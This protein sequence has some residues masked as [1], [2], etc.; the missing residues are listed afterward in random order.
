MTA[1]VLQELAT[2][3][4]KLLEMLQHAYGDVEATARFEVAIESVFCPSK[5]RCAHSP[6]W[7]GSIYFRTRGSFGTPR[8]SG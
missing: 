7:S 6:P 8:N 1:S 4:N 3:V 2:Y 5:S